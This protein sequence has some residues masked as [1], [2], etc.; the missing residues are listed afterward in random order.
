MNLIK[1]AD[2]MTFKFTG[3]KMT[4]TDEMKY[5]AEKKFAKLDKFFEKETDAN[6]L[7]SEEKGDK[8]LEITLYHKGMV[9]RAEQRSDDYN[10]AV[11]AATEVIERQIRK[12]KTKLEKRLRQGAFEREVYEEADYDVTRHKR[13]K[14]SE[15]SVEDAILQMEL[16]GHQFFMFKNIDEDEKVSVVY[17]RKKGGYGLLEDE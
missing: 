17:K 6:I 10:A 3:K 5:Y 8:I 12:H 2:F 4:V 1:G 13:F 11:D 9:Y 15:M 7:F 16:L 14:V